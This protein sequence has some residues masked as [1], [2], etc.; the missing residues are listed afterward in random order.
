MWLGAGRQ[1]HEGQRHQGP[2]D[3]QAAEEGGVG[4]N[5]HTHGMQS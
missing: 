3:A 1:G 2:G 5:M 4:E